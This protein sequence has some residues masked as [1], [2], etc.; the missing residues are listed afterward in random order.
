MGQKEKCKANAEEISWRKYLL[1]LVISSTDV[2]FPAWSRSLLFV[3]VPIASLSD[4]H[5]RNHGNNIFPTTTTKPP[6]SY[7]DEDCEWFWTHSHF[8]VLERT[9]KQHP[10]GK[11]HE[12][13]SRPPLAECE[14]LVVLTASEGGKRRGNSPIASRVRKCHHE[15]D[16]G[17]GTVLLGGERREPSIHF[18]SERHF[19]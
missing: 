19:L 8:P 3:E 14:R 15:P 11:A 6:W 18:I 2:T 10:H 9:L 1:L 16:H 7:G 13:H 5:C 17:E 12:S 4:P